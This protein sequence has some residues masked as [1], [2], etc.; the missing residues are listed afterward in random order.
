MGICVIRRTFSTE[1]EKATISVLPIKTGVEANKP[2]QY[3]FSSTEQ[4]LL[5]EL[6]QMS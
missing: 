5:K 2:F 3:L 1:K 6:N 4:S